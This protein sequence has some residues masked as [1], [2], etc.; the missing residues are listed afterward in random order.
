M[1]KI[2]TGES[3]NGVNVARDFIHEKYVQAIRKVIGKIHRPGH[4]QDVEW[5]SLSAIDTDKDRQEMK[6]LRAGGYFIE[7]RTRMFLFDI[8]VFLNATIV[9]EDIGIFH[10]SDDLTIRGKKYGHHKLY[11]P[12]DGSPFSAELLKIQSMGQTRADNNANQFNLETQGN[13]TRSEKDMGI[14]EIKSTSAKT[15]VLRKKVI[16]RITATIRKV[17]KNSGTK[18]ELLEEIKKFERYPGITIPNI[19]HTQYKCECRE[20][21]CGGHAL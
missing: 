15:E 4:D 16:E 8:K 7:D 12:Y 10:P 13:N 18:A 17:I 2:F 3:K 19:N 5:A 21:H 6:R 1:Q 14:P 20:N 11:S 9:L